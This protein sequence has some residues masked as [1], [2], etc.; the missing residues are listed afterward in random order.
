MS[1]RWTKA[2]DEKLRR[3]YEREHSFAAVAEKMGRS[4]GAC[5]NRAS[6]LGLSGEM[7]VRQWTEDEI[8]AIRD[9]YANNPGRELDLDAL[10]Y[11]MGR[12]RWSVAMKASKL[13]VTKK[14]R[15][16]PPEQR[17]R[18]PKYATEEERRA[19]IGAATKQWIAENGHPRG[20]LGFKPS[21]EHLAK[22]LEGSAEARANMTAEEREE[23]RRRMIETRIERYGTA[24]PVNQSNPYSRTKSGKR[25]DLDGQFFRSSWEANYARY[26]NLLQETGEIAGW[27]YE[28]DTF[29]FPG[30]ERGCITYTPDFKV[31]DH[32]GGHEYHEVKGW[33]DAKSKTR[34]KRMA[35]HFSE[36]ALHLIGEKQYREIERKVGSGL[37]GW[38]SSR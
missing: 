37:E 9:W 36:E 14:S 18:A 4:V 29:R 32:D 35:K 16:M 17:K 19:A 25:D 6:R 23:L 38:E 11:R 27:E 22:M 26:L 31:F 5:R 28:P 33:L 30:V 10:A 7:G 1:R 13:G 15:P 24:G 34:L 20:A 8:Q 2:E 21:P 12:S 3:L